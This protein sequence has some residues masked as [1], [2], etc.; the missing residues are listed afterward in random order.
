MRYT[1]TAIRYTYGPGY[2]S[3]C[4]DSLR[5]E[6]SGDRNPVRA[7]FS[8]PAQT[9]SG[10]HPIYCTVPRVPGLFLWGKAAG[11]GGWR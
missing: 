6:K 7:R 3:R 9:G 4:T 10:D 5:A 1:Y 11:V 8:A 2:V